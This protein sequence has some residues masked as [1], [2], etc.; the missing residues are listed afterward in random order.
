[1]HRHHVSGVLDQLAVKLLRKSFRRGV[2]PGRDQGLP[3][4]QLCRVAKLD[5]G[6]SPAPPCPVG[7]PEDFWLGADKRAC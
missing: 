2:A 6:G 4:R 5:N 7:R 1:M 3:D